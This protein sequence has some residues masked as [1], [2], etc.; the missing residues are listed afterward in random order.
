MPKLTFYL[1]ETECKL[2]RKYINGKNTKERNDAV[3]E[4]REK[5]GL[6]LLLLLSRFSR[7]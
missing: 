2:I 5:G 4:N 3:K 6:L 7:V 1:E